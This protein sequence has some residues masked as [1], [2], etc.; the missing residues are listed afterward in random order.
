MTQPFWWP[1]PPLPGSPAPLEALVD[2]EVVETRHGAFHRRRTIFALDDRYGTRRLGDALRLNPRAAAT[3]CRDPELAELDVERLLF[4]DTETTGLAG[5]TGTY[6]FLVGL[7]YFEREHT[8]GTLRFVLEQGFMRSYGEERAM[9]SWVADRLERFDTLATFNGRTFDVPL[10]QTRFIM[11]R[12]R[13]D[14]EGLLQFD[15]LPAARRLWRLAI[16]SC[17]LQNLER[18]VL[19]V[20][21]HDDV[22][23]FLIPAIYHQY[24][25]DGDGRYVKRVFDHNLADVLAIVALAIRACDV[26]EQGSTADLPPG[27]RPQGKENGMAASSGGSETLSAPL[28]AAEC[29]SLGRL[30][31]QLGDAGA[32]ERLYR[33][34]LDGAPAPELRARATMA[35]AALLKRSRRHDDAAQLWQRLADEVPALS[36]PALVELAKYWEHHR[37]DLERAHHLTLLARE[38]WQV[39]AAA[40]PSLPGLR[41]WAGGDTAPPTAPDDFTHRLSRLERKRAGDAGKTT[42]LAPL[43]LSVSKGEPPGPST[44]SG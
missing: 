36:V 37:R 33:R 42:G 41:R 12:M 29:V 22:E 43:T 5:G 44:R 18:H 39:V 16:G 27:P 9:L 8:A 32:A 11:G 13:V 24:L 1:L 25:R 35:L 14:V 34:A 3:L 19:G 7:G 40:G 17:A 31:E 30:L 4:L 23:S 6:A 21:R 10:L 28:S 15:L 38:R 20:H 2:G 26:F